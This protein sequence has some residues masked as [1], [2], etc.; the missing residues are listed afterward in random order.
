M[1][2]TFKFVQ[3][4]G[5]EEEGSK[6][7]PFF[8]SKDRDRN[9]P[10][11]REAAALGAVWSVAIRTVHEAGQ[12]RESGGERRRVGVGFPVRGSWVIEV[13]ECHLQHHPRLRRGLQLL[14][15]SSFPS[16]QIWIPDMGIQ[17]LFCIAL[18][19]LLFCWGSV[20]GRWW[21]KGEERK[22]WFL[23]FLGCVWVSNLVKCLL[24][25]FMAMFT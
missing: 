11:H 8:I 7:N 4:L 14:G 19:L 2:W 25:K 23:L 12:A 17:V 18:L 10:L 15:A 24:N 1:L 6:S 20:L 21:V 22:F 13:H 9:V 5:R 3:P 16:L